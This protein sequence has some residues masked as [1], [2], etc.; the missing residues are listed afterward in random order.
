MNMELNYL[1]KKLFNKDSF[2]DL[3]AVELDELV[4]QYPYSAILQFFYTKKLKDKNAFGYPD[5]A[6][7]SALYFNNP[8]WL[9]HLINDQDENGLRPIAV[10]AFS[11]DEKVLYGETA[12]GINNNEEKIPS[13]ETA[14]TEYP[15]IALEPESE[16]QNSVQ[17]QEYDTKELY[18][19]GP[20]V[21]VNGEQETAPEFIS[22]V[23]DS[24]KMTSEIAENVEIVTASQSAEMEPP[25]EATIS[26]SESTNEKL[27]GTEKEA[28]AGEP[29]VPIEPLYSI[30][31]FA[32]QG[33]RLTVEE[34]TKDKLGRSLK[35]FTEWL[36][37]MKRIHPEKMAES[38]DPNTEK[39]IQSVAEHS[40]DE[41]EVNTEAMAEV[42][43]KQGRLD[44]AIELFEKLSL[45]NPAKSA[46]FAAKIKELKAN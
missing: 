19:A 35:S 41:T 28:G 32:S 37:A 43:A 8:H 16:P 44:K 10:T 15:D 13:R 42:L 38:M 39:H 3:S 17:M 1:T 11:A 22:S 46:Y 20:P 18:D 40:N 5:A 29:L 33:I 27:P 6:A 26:A 9:N 7:R 2:R 24:S 25:V 31:Y 36:K 34:E 14:V 4:Q 12:L 21:N 45:L 23:E 30:D